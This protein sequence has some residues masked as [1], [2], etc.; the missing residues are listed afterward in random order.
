MSQSELALLYRNAMALVFPSRFEGFGL[1]VLEAFGFGCPVIC[2]NTTS[3][4]EL[5][6][7]AA[8]LVSPDDPENIA[9]GMQRV[10][11]DIEFRRRLIVVGHDRYGAY[12]WDRCA[13]ALKSAIHRVH[14]RQQDPS[15]AIVCD[16]APLVTIVTPS[17]NQGR[18]I[19]RTI[20]SVLNQNYPNIEYRVVDGASTDDTVDVLRSYGKRLN[21]V[22][23]PDRGQAHA[24][25]KGFSGG[26]GEIRGYLNSD[27]TLLPNAIDNVVSLFLR[28]NLVSMYYGDANY[29]DGNDRIT[30]SYRT[31]EYSFGR[32]MMDCCICQPAAF[33]TAKI[34]DKIGPFDEQL[35][36][37]MDY[38][39]W[40]RI[41]RAGGIIRYEPTLLANSR[42]YP[43]TKTRSARP[44]I[45]KEIFSICE[46]HG[47]YVSRNY[48]EGYWDMNFRE[49]WG[50]LGNFLSKLPYF[51]SG[52]VEYHSLRVGPY[53]LGA[54]DAA[55]EVLKIAVRRLRPLALL[56]RN[57]IIPPSLKCVE[58][59]W[60]DGWLG[61]AARF[62]SASL[63]QGLPL[64]LR[65]RA[66]VDCSVGFV[67]LQCTNNIEKLRGGMETTI[68]FSGSGEEL[69][70]TFDAF[71][72]DKAGRQISFLITGTN[73]FTEEEL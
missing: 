4:P 12:S 13:L 47:G 23:E 62:H 53:K 33:W 68:E 5:A 54:A 57:T 28:D 24:I 51:E 21:W 1:P 8:V 26:R 32:L 35:H 66:A 31:A 46:R 44:E 59:F 73:L 43:D 48:V 30:G 58:G 69:V 18:F 9:D 15:P 29:I 19:R 17:F 10:A 34:A 39:Y 60:L 71:A 63:S 42:L 22:S 67:G 11:D 50:R 25:N 16:V 56:A 38:D 20:D 72:I 70:V 3:L 40:L 7:D 2:S 6:N 36:Y 65:G 14:R 55:R 37:A 45:Y 49:R 64:W 41:D 52:L 27:D 61:P